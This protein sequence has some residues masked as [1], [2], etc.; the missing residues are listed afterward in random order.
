MSGGHRVYFALVVPAIALLAVFFLLPL[1]QVLWLSVSDPRP[2]VENYA[3]LV[4][5]PLIL[6]IWLTTLRICAITTVLCVALGYLVALAMTRVG[7]RHRTAMIFCILVTFSFSILV[8]GFAFVMLLRGEGVV[9]SLL[10]ALGI[11][12]QP[13]QLVRNELGVLIG[14][15][16]YGLPVAI[17][18]IYTVMCGIDGRLVTAARGL[19]ASSL[20]WFRRVYLPLTMP[21]VISAAILVFITSLGFFII[22]AMLGGGRV[23][24]IAEYIRVGFEETLRWGHATMLATTLLVVVL[25]VLT[26]LARW[27]TCA[28]C[29]ADERHPV[30]EQVL[31]FGAAWR[32]LAGAGLPGAADDDRAAGVADRPALSRTAEARA[33][34][35]AISGRSSAI[36]TGSRRSVKSSR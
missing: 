17:L 8:R 29:S 23:V 30:L 3:E 15:A 34:A 9:N 11:I 6:R 2:G 12:R 18:P 32:C 28:A 1:L 33:V 22:P 26:G 14:M 16:H 31:A 5:N 19:G 35:R 13:L 7:A 4:Q 10:M 36:P 24:M 21:G 25:A 20:Q 27:S